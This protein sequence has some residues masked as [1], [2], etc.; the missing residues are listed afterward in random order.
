MAHENRERLLGSEWKRD[1]H[2]GGDERDRAH[3]R[4]REGDAAILAR[5][6]WLRKVR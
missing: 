5:D 2:E 1:E 3:G 6:A 4:G